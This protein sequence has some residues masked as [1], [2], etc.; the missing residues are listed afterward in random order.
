MYLNE[1][2][3]MLIKIC[4]TETV[5]VGRNVFANLLESL[6]KSLDNSTQVNYK[7]GSCNGG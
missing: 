7:L 4:G 5:W 1:N 6:E 3:K 2:R